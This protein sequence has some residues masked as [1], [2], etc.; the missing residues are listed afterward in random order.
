MY[1][2]PKWKQVV[3]DADTKFIVEAKTAVVSTEA[4]RIKIVNL[5]ST[6]SKQ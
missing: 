5:V 1:L 3:V 6:T 4:R 2:S